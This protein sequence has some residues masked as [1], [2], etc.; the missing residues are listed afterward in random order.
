MAILQGQPGINLSFMNTLAVSIALQQGAEKPWFPKM[1]F[2]GP[3]KEK[4]VGTTGFE[5]ATSRTPS[6]RATRLR[7]VPTVFVARVFRRGDSDR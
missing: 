6:V 4:M 7:Y 2:N 1:S 3:L 5:P